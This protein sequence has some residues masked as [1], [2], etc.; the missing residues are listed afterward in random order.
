MQADREIEQIES[1]HQSR[2]TK[3]NSTTTNISSASS[4]KSNKHSSDDSTAINSKA[5]S[6]LS[7]QSRK[8]LKSISLI[9]PKNS[10]KNPVKYSKV[11]Q[12]EVAQPRDG[13]SSY[14]ESFLISNMNFDDTQRTKSPTTQEKLSKISASV[15]NQSRQSGISFC[16]LTEF[17]PF[18]SF[19]LCFVLSAIPV[20][21]CINS[22]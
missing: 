11:L 4:S 9:Y 8:S 19:V 5:S 3:R 10:L 20:Y 13:V 15:L 7:Q 22:G 21:T 12:K 1:N 2:L 14:D 18:V 17:T 16:F 6:A